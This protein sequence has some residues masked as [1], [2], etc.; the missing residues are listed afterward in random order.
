MRQF[1]VGIDCS[2]FAYYI[3]SH[4]LG[5]CGIKLASL[6]LVDKAELMAAAE[7]PSW[8]R[9]GITS[10]E[11]SRWPE[12]VDLETV[13]RRFHK[14]PRMLTNVKRLTDPRITEPVLM[15]EQFQPGDLIYINGGYGEHVAVVVEVSQSLIK[16]ADSSWQGQGLGGAAISSVKIIDSKAGLEDQSWPASRIFK[17]ARGDRV[18]RLKVLNG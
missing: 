11:I 15:V 18:L 5:S 10:E 1:G 9:A 6:L 13:C 7:K 4:W 17:S 8:Q 2:G 14:D 3:L 16:L 12:T